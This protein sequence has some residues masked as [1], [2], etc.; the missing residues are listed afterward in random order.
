MSHDFGNRLQSHSLKWR[1]QIKPPTLRD[2]SCVIDH[3]TLL[4]PSGSGGEQPTEIFLPDVFGCF[5][6]MCSKPSIISSSSVM[7]GCSEPYHCIT[8]EETEALRCHEV[9][10]RSH[11]N[12]YRA[13]GKSWFL[14]LCINR[15]VNNLSFV[16]LWCVGSLLPSM[17]RDPKSLLICVMVL[18]CKMSF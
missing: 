16:H 8:R 4:S 5:L 2:R 11:A 17:G 18:Q 10:L 1:K 13:R 7:K 3:T 14:A 15:W 6:V 9:F 12:Q